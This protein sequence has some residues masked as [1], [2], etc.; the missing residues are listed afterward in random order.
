MG[1]WQALRMLE[2]TPCLK[3][4]WTLRWIQSPNPASV[5]GLRRT[6]R[7]CRVVCPVSPGASRKS[8]L[9]W[10]VVGF[11]ISRLF[12]GTNNM[13]QSRLLHRAWNLWFR[14]C[15]SCAPDLAGTAAPE[16]LLA[17]A[18]L[19]VP[20]TKI[21]CKPISDYTGELRHMI[22]CQIILNHFTS[23]HDVSYHVISYQIIPYHIYIY[24][25]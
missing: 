22:S 11:R 16:R 13:W 23:L 3:H 8:I 18:L 7:R 5:S 24:V 19:Q 25:I 17:L 1:S 9:C 14:V 12:W 2:E 20:V 10:T 15:G 21:S 6:Q 4:W